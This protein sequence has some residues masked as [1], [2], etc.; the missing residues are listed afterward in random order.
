KAGEYLPKNMEEKLAVVTN[1]QKLLGEAGIKPN[2][3]DIRD[4]SEIHLLYDGR[5]DILLGGTFEHEYKV[6]FIRTALNKSVTENFCGLLD[7]SQRPTARLR[8]L[9]IFIEENWKFPKYLLEDYKK[10]LAEKPDILNVRP[11]EIKN[12]EEKAESAKIN[13]G[14]ILQMQ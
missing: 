9:D 7:V 14:N 2:I 4:T 1:L 8:P 11:S 6:N 12:E 3:I 10:D 5:V 13:D